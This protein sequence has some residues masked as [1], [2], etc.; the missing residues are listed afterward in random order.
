MSSNINEHCQE[1]D[2]ELIKLILSF[3][4]PLSRLLPIP[5]R[6]FRPKSHTLN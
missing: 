1:G 4:L 5:G 3:G 2:I 6:V